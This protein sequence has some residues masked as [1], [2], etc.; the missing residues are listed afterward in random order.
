MRSIPQALIWEMLRHGR[1]NLLLGALAAN[2]LPAILLAALRHDGALDPT[3]PSQI[4]LHVV[5]VQINLFIFGTAGIFAAQ[6][7]PSRLYALPVPTS[8]L[9]AWHMLPAM[10]LMML[11]SAASSF[12]L[13]AAFDLGWPVWG[14]ALFAA[15]AVAALQA[16]IWFTEKSAWVVVALTLTV[17]GLGFWF[18]SRY[19]Q[20]FSQPT[21]LWNTVTPAEVATMLAMA[22]LAYFAAVVG[23]S[24][25]RRGD[26]CPSLGVQAW[27][28]RQFDRAPRLGQPFS[29]PLRA[30]SWYEWRQKG[31]AMPAMV[32][33]GVVVGCCLW[34][35]FSRDATDLVAGFV[36]GGALL[37]VAGLLGGIIMGN[38]GTS[39]VNFGMGPFLAT[40]PIT[41][42]DM[43]R[44]ILKTAAKS[45][46]FAWLIW[47]IAFLIVYAVLLLFRA[48]PPPMLPRQ[49]GWWYF[50]GMLV[51][52]WMIVG[53]LA[54]GSLTG[55]SQLFV[56]WFGLLL[57]V[58]I[59][60]ALFSLLALS[61][62]AREP[63]D[64]GVHA[65]S[66][67]LFVLATVG[68]FI[69]A[70]RRGL[71][72]WPMVAAAA[73]V[74]AAASAFLALADGMATSR[75]LPLYVL[76]VGGIALALAPLAAAPLALAW[77]RTR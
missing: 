14:P 24:R 38:S 68:A 51:V 13:N 11:F 21:R 42:I 19:G 52:A 63:F 4:V 61:R 35:A 56:I 77:N 62:A 36:A 53:L 18:K 74:W 72:G 27:L 65:A 25:N 60:L 17:G 71:I 16:T 1:G 41:N 37:A 44:I 43:A 30:Q 22:A 34:L 15:V 28:D 69:A 76:L 7:A 10:T 31:W 3:E 29:T 32:G 58:R 55:R 26:A 66:G 49:L 8:S 47:M 57:L 5:M 9:V 40:R 20:P 73:S 64:Q 6:G 50:P 33:F 48:A 23:V 12:A 46:F 59:G 39:D 54:S 70:Y 2:A 45:V 67:A 75:N